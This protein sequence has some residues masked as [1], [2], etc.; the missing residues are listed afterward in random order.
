MMRTYKFFSALTALTI[1]LSFTACGDSSSEMVHTADT[2]YI[3]QDRNL[4]PNGLILTDFDATSAYAAFLAY[5]TMTDVPLCNK[6]NCTHNTSSCIAYQCIGS[7]ASPL[8]FLYHDTLYWFTYQYETVSDDDG[9]TKPQ[10]TSTLKKADLSTGKVQDA[11][12]IDGL[13]SDC[14]AAYR[15]GDVLYMMMSED[16][17]QMA[18]GTWLANANSGA[19]YLYAVHLDSDTAENLGH[20]NDSPYASNSCL[21]IGNSYGVYNTEVH[22]LGLMEN[23]LILYYAY[24][25]DPQ[26]IMDALDSGDDT[27]DLTFPW[28]YEIKTYD[29]DSGAWETFDTSLKPVIVSEDTC[30]FEDDTAGEY[31]VYYADGSRSSLSFYPKSFV[32]GLFFSNT[33]AVND[34]TG[35]MYSFTEPYDVCAPTVID[36]ADGQYIL[37]YYDTSAGS[38]V[39]ESVPPDSLLIET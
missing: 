35:Q 25:E 22:I 31:P 32:N 28:M 24:T 38:T 36:F 12:T 13:F 39:Y 23:R 29:L 16:T 19:Q 3:T 33:G 20:V 7:D 21:E 27:W 10:V 8:H 5:D 2:A 18:N 14:T 1:F 26:D 30:V 9:G 11:L 17:H 4:Y 37:S 34:K 6:P 15:V